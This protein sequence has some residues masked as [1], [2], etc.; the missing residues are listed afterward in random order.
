MND[1]QDDGGPSIS[2]EAGDWTERV[3]ELRN[4]IET[5]CGR[6]NSINSKMLA[7]WDDQ[8]LAEEKTGQQI[9]R[10]ISMQ[11][12]LTDYLINERLKGMLS[13]KKFKQ[14]C[15]KLQRPGGLDEL[16]ARILQL[17]SGSGEVFMSLNVAAM[18]TH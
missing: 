2:P 9:S 7:D 5:A 10:E 16:Y 11:T 8:M 14:A 17:L 3:I 6:S 13:D 4:D 18:G 12:V 1:P 15:G